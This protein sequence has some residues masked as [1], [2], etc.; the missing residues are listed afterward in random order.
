MITLVLLIAF[1]FGEKSCFSNTIAGMARKGML[2][3]AFEIVRKYDFV[4]WPMW[5]ALLSGCRTHGNEDL[6]VEVH[7][8]IKTRFADDDH[9]LSSA[10]TLLKQIQCH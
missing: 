2:V 1:V 5:L 7:E 4:H 9:V 8:G 3:E 6:A 10:S